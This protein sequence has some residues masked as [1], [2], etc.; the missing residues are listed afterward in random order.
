MNN[1]TT[2]EASSVA[3]G[4][5]KK[6]DN[7]VKLRLKRHG[8]QPANTKISEEPKGDTTRNK[9][10]DNP[11]KVEETL[12]VAV[13]VNAGFDADSH[14]IARAYLLGTGFSSEYAKATE[15]L[16]EELVDLQWV[17]HELRDLDEDQF[18]LANLRFY[19][20]TI[21][22]PVD[23]TLRT[24]ALMDFEANEKRAEQHRHRLL[25]RERR[26]MERVRR[27]KGTL[28]ELEIQ[29]LTDWERAKGKG[30]S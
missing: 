29:I 10:D 3:A 9:N 22:L 5:Q 6:T 1:N 23:N 21:A 28:E 2:T 4:A 17:R 14:A 24:P 7:E 13:S 15:N 12:D 18:S 20:A 30:V 25:T 26:A 11:G 8:R 27:L 19:H 16:E